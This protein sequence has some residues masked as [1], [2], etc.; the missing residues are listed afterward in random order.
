[1]PNTPQTNSNPAQEPWQRLNELL[2]GSSPES[3]LLSR[4]FPPGN[5]AISALESL[6][7]PGV[8]TPD[9]SEQAQELHA[10]LTAL[11]KH[12]GVF[13]QVSRCPI[14]AITGLLNAGK[15]SLLASYLSPEN[16][17][18]VLRG[19]SNEAGT[20]RFV[21]WLPKVW[22]DEAELLSTLISFL[23][24]LFGHPPEH[25]SEDPAIAALQYNGRIMAESLMKAPQVGESKD[26]T[27][28]SHGSEP[29][30]PL[31]VP[32]IAY[33][34]GLNDLHL[35]LVDCPDIQTGFLAQNT[36]GPSG[37]EMA[38]ARQSHLSQMG[39]LCSAF[40]VVSKLNSL[41]DQGLIGIL[42]TLRDAMPGVPRL[43][44][45]NKIKARYSPSVVYEQSK[46]LIDRFSIQSVYVA[47]DFRSSLAHT[48]I[49]KR[50]AELSWAEDDEPLPIF[51]EANPEDAS[52][53]K[54]SYL[55]NLSRQL[56]TGVLSRESSRS[57]R[58]QLKVKA[59]ETL[60]WIQ[61]NQKHRSTQIRDGW[62]ALA[63]ACYEFMAERDATG[64]ATGLRLQAS[65]TI[66]S[67]MA[68]SLHRTAP[69]WM[70]FSLTIDRSARQLQTAIS[71]SASRF[72]ILQNA[73]DSVTKF[74]KRFRRGEGAQVVTPE[75]LAKTL[76][77]NDLH[78]AFKTTSNEH[79]K[80]GCEL[81]MKR[82][83]D[84]DKTELNEKE[85]DEWSKQVWASMSM[86]DKLWRS[87]QPLAVL[88]APLLAA[89]LVPFDGGGSAVL[90]FASAKELLAAAGIAA[91]MTPMATGGE[92]LRI[93][94]RETP[95]RQLSDLFAILC[96]SIGLPRPD[97]N[98]LPVSKCDGVNRNL[99][100]CSLDTK[101]A[102]IPVAVTTWSLNKEVLDQLQLAVKQL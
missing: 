70:R 86:K 53:S 56:D 22:W 10:D 43:L 93:V 88:T 61:S 35:G 100:P 26:S 31:S 18:R 42:Q 65:P 13:E 3:V 98:E 29:V 73:S 11:L 91:V 2:Q 32:L 67:Q 74:T 75:R 1:M 58:M 101:G 79:L 23:T 49:P 52:S 37:S 39:R 4:R 5:E 15:S 71:N 38:D 90:V 97:A 94:H 62:Q 81:A 45:V 51:F 84:E 77:T 34:A 41:H 55:I 80:L 14:V 92:A 63:D 64:K 82:F 60:A 25:L 27:D 17:P 47:Y 12:L 6:T 8:A 28:V 54:L 7:H 44:A 78:E 9:D 96:D 68:D 16:R 48:R 46:A 36:I 102:A 83:A 85:L 19:L 40:V 57:L 21:L 87:T 69:M 66:V 72:K 20:H 89:V 99:L 59:T 24:S 30:D 95:W 50:P 33:D 76:R